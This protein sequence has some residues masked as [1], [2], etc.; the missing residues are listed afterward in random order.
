MRI[1]FWCQTNYLLVPKIVIPKLHFS[2]LLPIKLLVNCFSEAYAK[3]RG[4]GECPSLNMP[5]MKFKIVYFCSFFKKILMVG[6]GANAKI[7]IFS[8]PPPLLLC[9]MPRGKTNFRG[10]RK[11]NLP[12]PLER[13]LPLLKKSWTRL[14]F[15]FSM[16]LSL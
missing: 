8:P 5:L 11:I 6:I 9:T 12:P 10:C 15:F 3:I 1:D 14:Y 7:I 2:L 4:R 16:L 13:N